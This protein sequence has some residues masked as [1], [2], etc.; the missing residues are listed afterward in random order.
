MTFSMIIF[1]VIN[2]ILV[3]NFILSRF[4]G[5]CPFLGV[6]KKIDTALGMGFAVIFVMGVAS[7]IT[8]ALNLLLVE[9][10]ILYLQT[11]VF[12]LVIA[13]LIQLVE[14]IVKRF[15]PG[16]YS[17]LG[18]YLPLITTNCA[19][20]GVAIMN[21]TTLT[22]SNAASGLLMAFINGISSGIGF[23]IAILILAG[24]RE[25]LETA[26]IPKRFKGFPIT[27]L[28]ASIMA[29]GFAAF[30]GFNIG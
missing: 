4:L 24:I 12:I 14:I 25:K 21:V 20:L 17:A 29:M 22:A 16:L 3:N 6:S 8:Y 28:I 11:I 30:S 13:S 26:D 7:V 5:I 18:V 27:L 2:A 10:N 1:I 23:T 9:A 15:S 19:V